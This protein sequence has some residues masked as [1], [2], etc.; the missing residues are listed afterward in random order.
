MIHVNHPQ[1]DARYV[2]SRTATG[3]T[4]AVL[5][6]LDGGIPFTFPTFDNIIHV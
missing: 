3:A 1:M 6:L 4:G 2:Y 5:G